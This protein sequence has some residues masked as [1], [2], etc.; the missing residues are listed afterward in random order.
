MAVH[1]SGSIGRA[2]YWTAISSETNTIYSDEPVWNGGEDKAMNPF[3]LLAASLIA[4]T[5]ATLRMYIDRKEWD[6]ERIDVQVEFTREPK[7]TETSMERRIAITGNVSEEQRQRILSIANACPVH[8][9]LTN[10]IH[11]Q[12][13]LNDGNPTI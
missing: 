3:E 10:T 2:H 8:R 4:C 9:I 11:I 12:T 1:V 6:V 7:D 13:S 5:C